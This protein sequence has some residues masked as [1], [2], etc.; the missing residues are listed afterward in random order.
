MKPYCKFCKNVKLLWGKGGTTLC[1]IGKQRDWQ[2]IWEYA[3]AELKNRDCKC[4]DFKPKFFHR[5]K[6]K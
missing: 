4:K 6:Y 3:L 2:G 1:D 5:R